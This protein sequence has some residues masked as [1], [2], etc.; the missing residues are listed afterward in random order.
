MRLKPI[1][2]KYSILAVFFLNTLLFYPTLAGDSDTTIGDL[3]A[4]I[5]ELEE[6]LGHKGGSSDDANPGA[7]VSQEDL[8]RLND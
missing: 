7:K 6:Q 8:E 3:S 2:L 5:A 4:R 1:Y